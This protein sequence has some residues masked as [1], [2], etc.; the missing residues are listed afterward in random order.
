M[1]ARQQYVSKK[2]MMLIFIGLIMVLAV[3]GGRLFYVQV[4]R[5]AEYEAMAS[6]NRAVEDKVAA[7]RG[8]I[9]DRNMNELAI[10]TAAQSLYAD[11]GMLDKNEQTDKAIQIITS[12]LQKD[13][14]TVRKLLQSN[15]NFVYIERQIEPELA[16]RIDKQIKDEKIKGLSFLPE[17]KRYYPYKTLA[18]HVLGICGVDNNGLEGIEFYYDKLIGGTPGEI[19][20]EKDG[21]GTVLPQSTHS[22]V[23]P[24]EGK[25]IVLTI[26]S[27]I[28]Y[29]VE[30]ELDK[31]FTDQKAEKAVAIVMDPQTGEILAMAS[32]PTFDPNNYESV[33]AAS[34]RNPA[35]SDV[36]EPGSTMKACIAAIGL[37]EGLFNPNSHIYCPGFIDVGDKTITCLHSKAHGDQTYAQLVENS[38]NVGFVQVG[39]EIGLDCFY[40]Y[41]DKF[42][43]GRSSG[44]DLPGEAEGIII[45][46]SSATK[47]DLATMSIG[48]ANAAT[49][50]QV[51]N[52]ISVLAN[53]GKMNR[54]HLLKSVINDKGEA[55][56]KNYG[57]YEEEIISPSTAAQMMTILEGEVERGT[58]INAQ[59]EGYRVAGKTGTAEKVG[60]TGAYLSNEYVVS[61]IGV[62]PCD[63]PRLA[64]LV[65]VDAPKGD[66]CTGGDIAA[67]V[68]RNIFKK[69]FDYLQVP[70]DKQIAASKDEGGSS[71]MTIVPELT[72]M[73]KQEAGQKLDDKGLSAVF[74]GSG[75]MVWKQSVL[76]GSKAERKSSVVLYLADIEPGSGLTVV[77]DFT[78][79]SIKKA[80]SLAAG[81]GLTM[82]PEG[83]GRAVEQNPE[84]GSILGEGSR[85]SVSFTSD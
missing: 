16:A 18:S 37:E 83:C 80:A 23:P 42:C 34:R 1:S 41:M 70:F 81:M 8:T 52:T 13:E 17:S 2:R 49:P 26:D 66:P 32:R 62:A 30:E 12:C 44:I 54:P 56:D 11:P 67:P 19:V 69:S 36:Y 14:Q 59:L 85:V 9:Y 7:E 43:F 48:Q 82:V 71:D 84:A 53:Q 31:V 3:L 22:Y 65:V 77:P 21:R 57:P 5:G 46:R 35:I 60:P 27:T 68:V 45:P 39:Q 25:D 20:S 4:W 58:G 10:S 29:I 78:G 38:C 15:E 40:S 28:Q 76:E 33:P 47:V 73:F 64:C 63:N 51:L 74:D 79:M 61:F 75:N 6:E 50:L 72:G 24:V 55:E